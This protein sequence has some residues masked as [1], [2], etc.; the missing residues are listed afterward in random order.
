VATAAGQQP[1]F[2]VKVAAAI[3]ED[4]A[5]KAFDVRT[6]IGACVEPKL[7]VSYL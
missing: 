7:V 4:V 3:V 5:A 6:N 2:P 1:P